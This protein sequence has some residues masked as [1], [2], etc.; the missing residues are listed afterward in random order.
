MNNEMCYSLP[1]EIVP[2]NKFRPLLLVAESNFRAEEGKQPRY[3]IFFHP[4]A[5]MIESAVFVDL[6]GAE[7]DGEEGERKRENLEEREIDG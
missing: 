5:G 3:R 4:D 1:R 2:R 6:E 7:G